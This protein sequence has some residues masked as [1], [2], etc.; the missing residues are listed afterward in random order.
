MR[1]EGN[2]IVLKSSD[3]YYFKEEAGIKPN[4][5]RIFQEQS[6]FKE[7]INFKQEIEEE[8]KNIEI[9]NVKSIRLSFKRQLRDISIMELPYSDDYIFIFSWFHEED[10]VQ[11]GYNAPIRG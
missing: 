8:I 6:E 10:G 3:E 4:T 1:I 11:I 5:V 7:V 9:Q 2:T